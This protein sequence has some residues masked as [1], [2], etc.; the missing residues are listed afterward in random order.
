MKKQKKR[1]TSTAHAK[2]H[3]R[4][5]LIFTPKYRKKIFTDEIKKTLENALYRAFDNTSI[6]IQTLAIEPDHVHLLV[7][8]K[9]SLSISY[10][11]QRL[12]SLSAKELWAN[13]ESY[14]RKFYWGKKHILW[15]DGYFVSTIGE[16]SEETVLNYINNQG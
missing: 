3:I 2:Y 6:D 15:T 7:T 11:V 4:Y 8:A 14:L 5:H 13:H 16:A 10:I 12:K 1:Y 9:P